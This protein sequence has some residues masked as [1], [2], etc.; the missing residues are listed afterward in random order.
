MKAR[1]YLRPIAWAGV[2]L[3]VCTEAFQFSLPQ[4]LPHRSRYRPPALTRWALRGHKAPRANDHAL[5]MSAGR[6]GGDEEQ[7]LSELRAK[8][9][10]IMIGGQSGVRYPA[11]GSMRVAG[12]KAPPNRSP[13]VAMLLWCRRKWSILLNVA[14]IGYII[15]F[16]LNPAVEGGSKLVSRVE[17]TCTDFTS[18]LPSG[19]VAREERLK[20]VLEME[21]DLEET[22]AELEDAA[23][24][25]VEA[26]A[27][28]EE[29]ALAAE[30][31]QRALEQALREADDGSASLDEWEEGEEGEAQFESEGD[32]EGSADEARSAPGTSS[33]K[34]SFAALSQGGSHALSAP[35]ASLAQPPPAAAGSEG[36]KTKAKSPRTSTSFVAAAAKKVSPSVCRI[37]IERILSPFA[38]DSPFDPFAPG[39]NNNVEQGQGSGVIFSQD[40]LVLTNAHVVAGADKVT[41][42][43]TDGRK[44]LAEVKGSDELTDLAVLKIDLDDTDSVKDLPMAQFGDSK[45]LEVGDWVIAVG[46]PVG[47]DST[48]TLGIVSSLKRS[49]NEVGIP[50]RKVSFIQ[51]DA[52]IN[53]GNSGG[54]LVNEYGEVVGINTAIRAYAEGIGFAIPINKAKSIM[55]ELASGK[56]IE[57]AY[58]GIQMSTVTPDYARQNNMDP[59]S[60][61]LLPEVDGAMIVRVF[62]TT[63]AAEG[64]LRRGDVVLE[65]QGHR[66]R[67]AEDAQ[68]IVDESGVGEVIAVKVLR[69]DKVL[70]LDVRARDVSEKL[71]GLK[72]PGQSS[73]GKMFK[74]FQDEHSN[75]WKPD[76]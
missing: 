44:F 51:T 74:L 49:A 25:Q 36:S 17:K 53:P 45:E 24:A 68:Q 3:V 38:D 48:V 1:E 18:V 43:L 54:P 7:H 35:V 67:T 61:A 23:L 33:L 6:R 55:Y 13:A 28:R 41:I 9:L 5:G 58:I 56:V 63:P 30:A 65:M 12:E 50:N 71:T 62:P 34:T 66:V 27:L 11:K 73:K 42:T 10:S 20:R 19:R 8:G 4:R 57:H 47:L 16:D 60:P 15:R 26:A 32:N 21:M 40:G 59:N 72:S 64:G 2:A 46:N 76:R 29:R 31:K 52:A 39:R 14:L 69:G 70:R 75:S 22:E 37:D